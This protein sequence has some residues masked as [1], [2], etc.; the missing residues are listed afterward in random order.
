M[1][2]YK[3]TV[4]FEAANGVSGVSAVEVDA[5]HVFTNADWVTFHTEQ[6]GL[7]NTL[8]ATFPRD[9]VVSVVKT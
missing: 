8:V 4:Q 6:Q 2:K 7:S 1:A 9:R 5:E 3:V